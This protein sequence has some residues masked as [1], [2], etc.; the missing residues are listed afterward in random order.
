MPSNYELTPELHPTVATCLTHCHQ[1]VR[2]DEA[3]APVEREADGGHI[4][5]QA[6]FV[7]SSPLCSC[8]ER[9]RVFLGPLKQAAHVNAVSAQVHK[10]A[11]LPRA[12]SLWFGVEVEERAF[13]IA[14]VN[15][16]LRDVALR[17]P[18]IPAGPPVRRD[19]VGRLPGRL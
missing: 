5:D 10:C 19:I 12:E 16:E 7:G 11:A 6:A 9:P 4:V 18:A 17:L 13:P 3:Q 2:H 14:R 8:V 15:P 1:G